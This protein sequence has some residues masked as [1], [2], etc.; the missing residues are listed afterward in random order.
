[1]KIHTIWSIDPNDDTLYLIDG[2]DEYTR[3]ENPSGFTEAV[4]KARLEHGADNVS[5]IDLEVNETAVRA[6]F[7]VP[8]LPAT[9]FT[10]EQPS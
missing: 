3:D 2:W 10:T 4:S 8:V 5:V 1:M 7:H 6:A 9:V